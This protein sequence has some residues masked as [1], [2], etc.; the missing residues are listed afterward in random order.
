MNEEQTEI[1]AA[2]AEMQPPRRDM[3]RVFIGPQ[4]IRAGWS[5]L[6]FVAIFIALEFVAAWIFQ[7]STHSH[8]GAKALLS[9]GTA[10]VQEGVQA[11]LVLIATAI[12]ARI[13]HR[14]TN[15]YGYA[16]RAKLARF[17]GGILCGFGAISALVGGLAAAGLLDLGSRTLHGGVAWEYAGAWAAVFLCVAIFEES[18]L[19][20]YLQ[21]TLARGMGFWWG[22]LVLSFVFGS[23]HG[24]NPG[25]TQVGLFSAGAI[26]LIFC[27]SLWYTGSLWWALGFH[28][29]WDWG[30]SYFYGTADSGMVAKGHLYAEHPTGALLW[31]GGP[32]GPEGSLL[33]FPLIVVI[34]LLMWLWWGRRK[35]REDAWQTHSLLGTNA[36]AP[37]SRS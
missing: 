31:S 22:A 11:V 14:R 10:L 13:E 26:G 29:A 19:R 8:P 2:A 21:Y 30:E 17:A 4:G 23:A 1:E 32:T 36:G 28:S 16:G 27:L 25:E 18:L 37:G 9:P 15:S 20:G 12:M 3:R 35:V 24:H 6:I 34:A 7:L 5:A 33:I